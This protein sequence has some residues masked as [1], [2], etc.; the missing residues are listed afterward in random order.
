MNIGWVGLGE[1]GT[2]M[3]KR[4]LD[5]GHA[6]TVYERGQGLAEVKAAGA[7]SLGDYRALAAASELLVLCVFSDAQMREVLFDGGALDALRPGAVLMFH[8]TGSPELA[9]ELGERAPA[10]AG[11]LEATFSGSA[12]DIAAGRL[13]IIAGGDEADLE[14]ARPALEGY[15]HL[16]HHVGPL[17]Q[18]QKVKLLNNL[19][20]AA[21]LMNAAEL[22]RMAQG[23]G[24]ETA[25][26]A[27]VIQTCSGGSYAM[28]LFTQPRPVEAAI[29]GARRY[30][31]K[32]VGVIARTARDAG[33]DVAS[34]QATI[35]YYKA[36]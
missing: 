33:L 12:M 10:G 27:Q 5:A 4:L 6:V 20:F 19:L 24:L 15:A 32:D 23:W 28:N 22:M 1:I 18:S 34:F 35:D 26:V 8:T 25:Q 21:N 36:E 11:V 13:T 16:I 29:E 2:A 17:G 14:K 31:T 3:V 7:Q 30:M 9:I